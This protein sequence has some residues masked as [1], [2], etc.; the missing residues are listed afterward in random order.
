MEIRKI[1]QEDFDQILS[2][3]EVF[4]AS[5]A[6]LIHPDT[7]TLAKTLTDCIA[8]GPYLEGF[9]MEDEDH[10][11]G[12]G[13]VAKSYSTE[14]G[15][16]CVWIE[17]IYVE[18]QYRG[19]GYGS[20]FLAFVRERYADQAVRI[21]LEAEPENHRAMAVYQKAGYEIL[22]YTQLVCELKDAISDRKE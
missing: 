17:D 9:I 6:L 8:D 15:G 14:A 12:Y 2:M 11:V 3:M 21:R 20:R 19:K 16:R 22:G 7:Q 18:P 4:Y 10:L 1:R 13:M 5:D